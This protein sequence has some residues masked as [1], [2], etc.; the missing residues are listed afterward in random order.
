MH[1]YLLPSLLFGLYVPDGR[2]WALSYACATDHQNKTMSKHTRT[3]QFWSESK[4]GEC[5]FPV[6]VV[7]QMI[8]CR[9][10]CY[11]AGPYVFQYFQSVIWACTFKVRLFPILSISFSCI[12]K[13]S[14]SDYCKLWRHFPLFPCIQCDLFHRFWLHLLG[15]AHINAWEHRD[16]FC[17]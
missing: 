7:D 16:N 14:Y 12:K 10:D 6:P 8:C 5:L 9:S 2:I 17:R 11:A 13:I 4:F 1:R 15:Y 3:F